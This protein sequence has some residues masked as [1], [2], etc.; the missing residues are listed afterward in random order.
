MGLE[1][2]RARL[3]GRQVKEG[4]LG[5][6]EVAVCLDVQLVHDLE[7]LE[8]ELILVQDQAKPQQQ[9]KARLGSPG[10]TDDAPEVAEVKTAVEAKKA[11]IRAASIRV[12]FR[13]LSSTRYQDLLNAHPEANERGQD[14]ADFFNA[15]AAAGLYQVWSGDE[16]VEGLTWDEIREQLSYGEWE[17]ITFSVLGLN[18][19]KVDVPFSLKPSSANRS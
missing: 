4:A 5:T 18:R 10:Q 17:S 12:V 19:G 14:Q 15:I 8:T 1:D 3:R 2:I 13:S 7:D 6:V 9:G 11:E 16:R